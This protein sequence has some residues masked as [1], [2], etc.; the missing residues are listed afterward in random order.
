M[1]ELFPRA[2]AKVEAAAGV[3]LDQGLRSYM[4]GVYSKV[5]LGLLAAG[6]VA[7]MTASVPEVRDMLFRTSAATGTN[8]LTGLTPLGSLTIMSPLIVLLFANFAL[9]RPSAFSTGA[10]YWSIVSLMGASMGALVLTFTGMSIASTFLICAAAFGALSLA[11]YMTRRDLTGLAAFLFVG[12][13][14]LLVTLAVN[15]FLHSPALHFV[16]NVVGVA[17]FAGLIACDT[18]RLKLAYHQ[19]GGDSASRAIATNYGA[20]S[21]FINFINLFQ[22]LLML[23]SGDRR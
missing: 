9:R 11:G 10:L 18:Q 12:L 7:Y 3:T 8:R 14:G 2:A 1:S 4:L 17:V 6:G 13:A 15:L 20:L 21:L 5:G 23:M 22:I 16:G 19:M